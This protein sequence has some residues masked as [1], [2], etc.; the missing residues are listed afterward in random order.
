MSDLAERAAWTFLQAFLAAVVTMPFTDADGFLVVLV[1]A[2][3]AG[4][5]AAKTTVIERSRKT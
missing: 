3:A 4:L 5:S 1:A 2:L